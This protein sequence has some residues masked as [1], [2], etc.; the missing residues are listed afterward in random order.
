MKHLAAGW[1]T[2][3]VFLF[4]GDSLLSKSNLDSVPI[5]ACCSSG[6]SA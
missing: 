1:L 6:C 5:A 2:V 3:V 4:F